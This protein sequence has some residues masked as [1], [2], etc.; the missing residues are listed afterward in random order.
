MPITPFSYPL[1]PSP[2]PL[3]SGGGGGG[4][5][6]S[7]A[8]TL[9]GF[10]GRGLLRPFRRD[11]KSDLVNGEGVALVRAAVGQVL[12]MRCSSADGKTQGELPWRPEVG[13]LLE[14]LRHAPNDVVTSQTAATYVRDALSRWEPRVRVRTLSVTREKSTP[15]LGGGEDVLVI[16]LRCDVVTSSTAGNQVLAEGIDVEA[17]V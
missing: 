9:E 13:S 15:T 14:L 8:G 12:G 16:K 6:S 17:R 2:A 3:D 5:P 4:V 1:T 10:L 11:L 7:G